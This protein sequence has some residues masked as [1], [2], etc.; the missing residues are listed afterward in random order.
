MDAKALL[1]PRFPA[2]G[3][4]SA[5]GHTLD[6]HASIMLYK[7]NSDDALGTSASALLLLLLIKA[8]MNTTS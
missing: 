3:F 2:G 4:A 8:I 1:D 6:C 5:P 7:R